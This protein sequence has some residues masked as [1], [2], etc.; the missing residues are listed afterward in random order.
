MTLMSRKSQIKFLCKVLKILRSFYRLKNENDQKR[1]NALFGRLFEDQLQFH[2][3][4]QNDPEIV[5]KKTIL[6]VV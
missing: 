2:D 3:R 4:P 5:F 1:R 6:A